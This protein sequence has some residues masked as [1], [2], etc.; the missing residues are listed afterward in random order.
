MLGTL[1]MLVMDL[2]GHLLLV[3]DQGTGSH[4]M[5]MYTRQNGAGALTYPVLEMALGCFHSSQCSPWN[6]T[7]NCHC[8]SF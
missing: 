2:A 5:F 4:C 1:S 6:S 3:N 7:A 8:C